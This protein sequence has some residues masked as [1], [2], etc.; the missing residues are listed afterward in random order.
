[1][2]LRRVVGH[3]VAT[4]VGMARVWARIASLALTALLALAIGGVVR[5][6]ARTVGEI[7]DDTRITAE[8]ITR[9]T[10][11]SPSNFVKIDVKSDSGVVT[12]SGTVDSTEK[13]SRAAQ[14]AG[15]VGGVKGLVNNIQVAGV[16]SPSDT[17]SSSSV[18]GAT[19]DATGTV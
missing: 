14:I 2:S 9:L 13:R 3:G 1:M 6:H 10:A 7:I 4:R 15:A 5:A 18:G 19:I 16:A 11:E 12:L 17:A 8:V